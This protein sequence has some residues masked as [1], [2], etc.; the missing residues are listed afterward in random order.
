MKYKAIVFDWDGTPMDPVTKIV[1][2]MQTNAE[3]LGFPVPDYKN[4]IGIGLF[5]GLKQLFNIE[6]QKTAMERC[7][8]L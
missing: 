5:A 1:E 8:H 4:V 3:Q 2:S 6:E 7:L